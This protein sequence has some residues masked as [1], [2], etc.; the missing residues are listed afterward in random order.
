MLIADVGQ[1][2]QLFGKATV[3]LVGEQELP[4]RKQG[5]IYL[6][7]QK[8]AC[9]IP[10]LGGTQFLFRCSL[11]KGGVWFGGTDEQP[12]LTQLEPHTWSIREHG[13]ETAFFDALKP[14]LIKEAEKVLL[15]QAQRQGDIFYLDFGFDWNQIN[16]FL[17]LIGW[18]RHTLT[19]T[20]KAPVFDT[21]H[22]IAGEILF[23]E[24]PQRQTRLLAR[25]TLKAPDHTDRVLESVHLVVQANCLFN[26][27][28]AD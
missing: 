7:D 27:A 28:R 25:G 3:E 6:P 24:T 2:S 26:P 17:S 5:I 18:S 23:V 22:T 4:S 1:P 12:F 19:A 13:N 14:Q 20:K 21:R 16:S 10:L 8:D 9:L 11:P 15:R